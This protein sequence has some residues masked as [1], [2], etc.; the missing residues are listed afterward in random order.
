MEE[1]E[2]LKMKELMIKRTTNVVA[3]QG[4]GRGGG[5]RRVG[6]KAKTGV[7]V[8]LLWLFLNSPLLCIQER[9]RRIASLV[10]S[11]K[12]RR[13]THFLYCT[14]LSY[15]V[16]VILHVYVGKGAS[17]YTCMYV[18]LSVYEYEYSL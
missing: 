15:P 5:G 14:C 10:E 7:L 3:G 11:W 16:V 2:T 17:S 18:P 9:R 4:G 6:F 13:T 8:S 1:E 12:R